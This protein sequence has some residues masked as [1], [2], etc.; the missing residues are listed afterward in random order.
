MT[1]NRNEYFARRAADEERLA[2]AATHPLVRATHTEFA[3]AYRAHAG[4][5]A[6][7]AAP[8]TPPATGDGP[9]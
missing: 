3:A 2:A 1:W 9:D 7:A 5:A 4:P 6:T 8:A